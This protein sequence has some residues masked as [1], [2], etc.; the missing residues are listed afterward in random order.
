M[1]PHMKRTSLKQYV[2]SFYKVPMPIDIPIF[3]LSPIFWEVDSR[4]CTQ[5]TEHSHQSRLRFFIFLIPKSKSLSRNE[6]PPQSAHPQKLPILVL[7]LL[8]SQ[9]SADTPS[10]L[11]GT[12]LI[13]V[14]IN[15]QSAQDT[16]LF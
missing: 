13:E 2:G 6:Y 14:G 15:P 12:V 11:T 1:K 10:L 9:S 7:K 8:V 16:S 3:V 5:S 4:L